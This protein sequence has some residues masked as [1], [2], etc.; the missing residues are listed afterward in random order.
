MD[1]NKNDNTFFSENNA[2]PYP[3]SIFPKKDNF[4]SYFYD[5]LFGEECKFYFPGTFEDANIIIHELYKFED[6]DDLFGLYEFS[7][8][9]QV[10]NWSPSTLACSALYYYLNCETLKVLWL[11]PSGDFIKPY[12]WKIIC[13][14]MHSSIIGRDVFSFIIRHNL[15]DRS[16]EKEIVRSIKWSLI[17]PPYI[18]YRSINEKVPPVKTLFRI[19]RLT[20]LDRSTIKKH[21]RI[22]F[23]EQTPKALICFLNDRIKRLDLHSSD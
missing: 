8:E 5:D 3:S 15:T 12:D 4:L 10:K 1:S 19:L 21:I 16:K 2:N 14:M 11:E 9:N 17:F 20:T 22:T 23:A 18:N 13:Y 7:F 6:L